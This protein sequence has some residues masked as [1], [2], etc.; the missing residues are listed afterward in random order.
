MNISSILSLSLTSGGIRGI[1][2]LQVLK[3][4]ERVLGPG[5]PIQFFFDLIVGTRSVFSLVSI[6]LTYGL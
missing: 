4:I 2:E 3:A 6:Y 1:S 5:L